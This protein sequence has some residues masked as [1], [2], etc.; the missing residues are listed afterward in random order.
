MCPFVDKL[1]QSI[2]LAAEPLVFFAVFVQQVG[3]VHERHLSTVDNSR[4]KRIHAARQRYHTRS[5]KIARTR[6]RFGDPFPNHLSHV[7]FDAKR[8]HLGSDPL[9][10]GIFAD[11]AR[12]AGRIGGRDHYGLFADSLTLPSGHSRPYDNT[13]PRRPSLAAWMTRHLRPTDGPGAGRRLA[14]E[15]WQ[16]GFLAAVD[17]EHKPIVSLMAAS[18]IGKTLIALGIGIRAAVD[19]Q[20]VLM[21]SST[22]V[23]V[24]DLARRLDSTLEHAPSLGKRFPSPRSGPGARAS[25]K[26]RRVA[27]GGWIGL[28]ASGSASQLASR[29]VK[30]AL[31]DEVSRWPARVRSGEG[32]PLALLR[33]RLVDWG[34][35]GRLLAISSP[36]H[37]ADAIALMFRDGDRR[38]V[39]YLCQDC[40]RRTPF[41]WDQVTGRERGEQPMISCVVCGMLHDEKARRKML[42]TGVWVPQKDAVDE[43]SISFHLSRLDSA[44]ASL[45]A[46]VQEFRRAERGAERGDPRAIAAFRNVVL[47]MPGESGGADVD[48]LYE[49]RGLS[50]QLA[51]EQVCA[52]VD[53]QNDR[54][55]FVVLGFTAQNAI[56]QVVHFG[57]VVGDPRDGAVWDALAAE[58]DTH[59]TPLPISVVSVDA[60][61]LT[62]TVKEQCARRRWWIPTI[63][64][65]G[66]G[67]PIA[68][69][70]GA[71]GLAVLGKDDS[72]SFWTG[73][74][75][76]DRVKTPQTI[77]R[78][79]IG[80]LLAAEALTAVGGALRWRKIEN[81]ENHYW[82]CCL[83]SIHARHF[84][85]LTAARR[86]FR[87]VAV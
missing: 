37:P 12:A 36:V 69:V 16:R 71:S 86:P 76:A 51:I 59:R 34:D 41:G 56:V 63:G 58:L 66:T 73:R 21:A 19:G 35:D 62:S 75:D 52:G 67:Q 10:F 43:Q 85:P 57:V 61:F 18:Q 80:E 74:V 1:E 68:R 33:A 42:R 30:I 14:L 29:T 50:G 40:N 39:E 54:L 7:G 11:R 48:R 9:H 3:Q 20:G 15:P 38:R 32:H 72:A 5:V 46:I 81:L 2:H 82:D 78:K 47:G 6:V 23:S 24:R 83:L 28:A 25:W 77:S 27:G 84:R 4:L 65:A 45:G 26:D 55:V 60:G 17:R 8:D 53:V 87:V 70:I 22:E 31:A 64:R 49:R 13:V 79:E 44:R